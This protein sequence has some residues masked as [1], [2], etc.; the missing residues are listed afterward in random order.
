MHNWFIWP[1]MHSFLRFPRKKVPLGDVVEEKI[2]SLQ[3]KEKNRQ[4]F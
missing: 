4:S 3:P 1:I 2:V